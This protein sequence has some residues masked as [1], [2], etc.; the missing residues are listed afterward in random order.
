MN[1]IEEFYIYIFFLSSI[2]EE[3]ELNA[4]ILY[5]FQFLF[6]LKLFS[7]VIFII[8]VSNILLKSKKKLKQKDMLLLEFL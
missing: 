8:F 4:T 6:F 3:I 5:L 1:Q 2:Q 7:M